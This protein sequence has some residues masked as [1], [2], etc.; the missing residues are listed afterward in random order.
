[1]TDERR[2][3]LRRIGGNILVRLGVAGMTQKQLAHAMGVHRNMVYEYTSGRVE[4]SATRLKSCARA[5]GC[6]MDDLMEGVGE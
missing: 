5:L 2:R 1:M 4:M 3:D 6:S